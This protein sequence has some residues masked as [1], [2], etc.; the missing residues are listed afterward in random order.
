MSDCASAGLIALR[1]RLLTNKNRTKR[2]GLIVKMSRG[3]LRK[4]L[5]ARK[6][7]PNNLFVDGGGAPGVLGCRA[8]SKFGVGVM[9]GIDA[10]ILFGGCFRRRRQSE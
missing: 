4:K 7:R 6:G 1:G 3:G 9:L 8:T 2:N 10:L 5:S